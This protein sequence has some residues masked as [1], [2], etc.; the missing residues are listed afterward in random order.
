MKK[1]AILF[2]IIISLITIAACSDD[3]ERNKTS[4]FAF[5][6]EVNTISENTSDDNNIIVNQDTSSFQEATE[7]NEPT[8]TNRTTPNLIVI[9]PGHQSKG[10]NNQEPVGPGSSEMKAKVTGGT[11]GCVTGVSEYELN[12]QVSLK[13][14]KE[15]ES[16]GY[17]VLMTRTSNNVDISNKE[18]AIIANEAN[19][20]AFIRIH[21]NGSENTSIN[22]VMTICQT[23][24]N[25]YNAAIYNKSKALSVCVLNGFVESTG[26]VRQSVWETDSMSG[27][28]WA[29]VPSTIIEMGY[30][31]NQREDALMA[32]DDYQNKIVTGI[33][34]GIENYFEQ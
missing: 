33:A 20:A 32:T 6:S 2:L 14:K 18:R 19:A 29:Q 22:G 7:M 21:A 27:I 31:T 24:S 25:P 5:H 16:R 9:D 3:N 4:S 12:L 26:A 1:L 34:N 10:N 11:S 23:S 15:L 8:V 28:N 13:L 30:M 17:Q